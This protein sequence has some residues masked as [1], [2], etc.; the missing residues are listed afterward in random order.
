MSSQSDYIYKTYK[1]LLELC[2]SSEFRETLSD[3]RVINFKDGSKIY[4]KDGF[5]ISIEKTDHIIEVYSPI[6]KN[7]NNQKVSPLPVMNL[8]PPIITD[9][10]FEYNLVIPNEF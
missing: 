5:P 8:P 2:K 10:K 9:S 1:E 3:V 4:F 7:E 6:I